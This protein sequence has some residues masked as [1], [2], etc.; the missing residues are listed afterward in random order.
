MYNALR[1]AV[2]EDSTFQATYPNVDI[3]VVLDSWIQNPGSPVVNVDVNMNTGLISITQ[4]KFYKKTQKASCCTCIHSTYPFNLSQFQFYPFQDQ[5]VASNPNLISSYLLKHQ[6][7]N[8][9]RHNVELI[10]IQRYK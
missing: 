3:G 2:A 4:V 6:L 9:F 8:S 1:Q 5:K 10:K 7:N